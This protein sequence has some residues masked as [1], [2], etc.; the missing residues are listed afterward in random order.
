MTSTIY[1]S[2]PMV[3]ATVGS[4]AAVLLLLA[5]F[6][7]GVFCVGSLFYVCSHLA[8]NNWLLDFYCVL[9]VAWLSVFFVSSSWCLG[10]VYSL[11]L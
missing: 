2:H 11:L 4:K 1:L 9:A 7:C 5:P 10:L 8:K 3:S 6:V